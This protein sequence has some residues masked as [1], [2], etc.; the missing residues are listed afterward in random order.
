M[1]QTIT[2]LDVSKKN[3][4]LLSFLTSEKDRV[5]I[6]YETLAICYQVV[7]GHTIHQ[8]YVRGTSAFLKSQLVLSTCFVTE[9]PFN[10]RRLHI[11]FVQ[12]KYIL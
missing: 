10:R 7:S 6:C 11:L 12:T 3:F 4:H 1:L 2:I 9:S 5:L 8:L